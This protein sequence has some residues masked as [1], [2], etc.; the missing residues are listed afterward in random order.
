MQVKQTDEVVARYKQKGQHLAI[1][2]LVSIPSIPER[3]FGSVWDGF[4]KMSSSSW[5]AENS[6]DVYENLVSRAWVQ[7]TSS[8]PNKKPSIQVKKPGAPNRVNRIAEELNQ[9]NPNGKDVAGLIQNLN[10]TVHYKKP[11]GIGERA[12]GSRFDQR[13]DTTISQ[14]QLLFNAQEIAKSDQMSTKIRK[15]WTT[16]IDGKSGLISLPDMAIDEKRPHID[17]GVYVSLNH[18]SLLLA[19]RVENLQDQTNVSEKQ[20]EDLISMMRTNFD[21]SK[22]AASLFYYILIYVNYA[23]AA[24]FLFSDVVNPR[25]YH[26]GLSLKILSDLM[27]NK[28]ARAEF[29]R[30]ILASTPDRLDQFVAVK[31][32][33]SIVDIIRTERRHL[34]TL[35]ETIKS[36]TKWVNI[37][38]SEVESLGSSGDT[39]DVTQR[40]SL[41]KDKLKQ[42]LVPLGECEQK[43][44]KQLETLDIFSRAFCLE[45][46]QYYTNRAEENYLE[47]DNM[48]VLSDD[49]VPSFNHILDQVRREIAGFK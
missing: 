21:D 18:P 7:K 9:R 12:T 25:A 30:V 43:I 46:Y 45:V 13:L 31:P 41:V 44:S 48:K 4:E 23:D 1:K 35:N 22:R 8:N 11:K 10:L 16:C 20:I 49:V 33:I 19:C 40:L 28:H 17:F 47:P 42:L 24:R 37:F 29:F 3:V 36:E 32:I 15:F 39:S 34:T 26:K 2:Q 6:T 14:E 5:F 38:K 27:G